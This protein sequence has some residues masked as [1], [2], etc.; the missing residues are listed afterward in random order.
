MYTRNS[1]GKWGNEGGLGLSQK[2]QSAHGNVLEFFRDI[3]QIF[4]PRSI[5]CLPT[6]NRNSHLLS[7]LKTTCKFFNKIS[8]DFRRVV[9]FYL[10]YIAVWLSFIFASAV[11]IHWPIFEFICRFHFIGELMWR[12]SVPFCAIIAIASLFACSVGCLI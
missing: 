9:I 12:R 10:S 6:N 1:C 11:W 2:L 7:K 5:T 8:P 4:Q 3:K